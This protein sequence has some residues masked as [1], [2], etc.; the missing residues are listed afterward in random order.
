MNATTI[1]PAMVKRGAP[2]STLPLRLV[3]TYKSIAKQATASMPYAEKLN[4]VTKLSHHLFVFHRDAGSDTLKSITVM[5]LN[6]CLFVRG[7]LQREKT[8]ARKSFVHH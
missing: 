2:T 7:N 3:V 6:T 8:I 1:V 4:F 5:K